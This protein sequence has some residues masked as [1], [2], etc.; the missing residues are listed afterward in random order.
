[1]EIGIE[2]VEEDPTRSLFLRKVTKSG[3]TRYLSVAAI[4]P[5][6]WE[7]VKVQIVTLTSGGCTLK[8][9]PIR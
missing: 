4:L 1:M 2:R 7:N 6:D 3:K 9:T 8:I 5:S